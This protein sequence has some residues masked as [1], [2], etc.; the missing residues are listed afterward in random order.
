MSKRQKA[1]LGLVKNAP[2]TGALRVRANYDAARHGRRLAG[3]NPPSTGPNRAINGLQTMRNRSRD[4]ARNEWAAESVISNLCVDMIGTGIVARPLTVKKNLKATLT[5]LWNEWV[6]KAD[7]DGIDSFYGLQ[8]LATRTWKEAGEVFVRFRPRRLSD[9]LRVPFQIQLLEPEMCPLFDRDL[10]N[11]NR[12]RDG[13][14]LDALDRR[15]N[16][17]MYRDHPGDNGGSFDMDKMYAVP[18][19]EVLHVFRRRR[20]GQNR[21]VPQLVPTLI[22]MKTVGDYDDAVVERAKLQ[23]LYAGFIT[24]PEPPLGTEGIDPLTGQTIQ[25]DQAGN[26]MVALEPGAMVE[27]AP[28]EHVEFSNPPATGVGYDDFSRQQGL[29]IASGNGVPYELLTG[30]IREISDRTLRVVIQQYRRRVEHDQWQVIIEMLCTP[31]WNRFVETAAMAG[32][33]PVTQV[34]EAKKVAWAPQ[35]WAYIHP[36]QDVQAKALEIETGITSRSEVISSR[37]YDPEAVD[38]ERAAE[39]Q[40]EIDL[41]IRQPAPDPNA[42]PDPQTE[43]AVAKL[44]AERDL[45]NAQAQATLRGAEA[46]AERARAYAAAQ[47]AEAERARADI[48]LTEARAAQAAAEGTVAEA[49]VARLRAQAEMESAESEYRRAL[50]ERESEARI[51][52]YHERALAAIAEAQERTAAMQAAEDFARQQRELVL[53]AE[54]AR[55]ETAML[56]VEA[57]KVGLAELQEG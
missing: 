18:A 35:A 8:T 54:R 45:L 57:A 52:E 48:H 55:A 53:Q 30:D 37:G 42:Q 15:V 44:G 16:Y 24:R 14:E 50:A 17:W 21:G 2:S 28:G 33:I 47:A 31:V 19:S 39:Q 23:N 43:A 32:L 4:A 1:K 38:A 29:S 6:G 13:I 26:P 36:V 34:A 25:Y 10:P 20:P 12:I 9:G 5:D 3:W 11:G 56:E 41:G 40:R 46:E 22:K 7:A 49:N 27:L 51:V